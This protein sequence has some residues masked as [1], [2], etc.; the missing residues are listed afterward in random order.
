MKEDRL[1]AECYK[2][3]HNSYPELRG[4]LCYNLNNSKNKIDGNKNKAM[5]LQAGRSDLV[6]YYN[7]K[8][9]HIEMKSEDGKQSD[10]QKEWQQIIEKA[11]FK[12]YLS[13]SLLEFQNIIKQIILEY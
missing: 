4:L 6:F 5:G 9:H 7:A 10:S 1:Q 12:Y 3:F 8:A 2:W 13:K 11:G